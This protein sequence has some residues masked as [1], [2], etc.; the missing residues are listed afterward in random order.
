MPALD[1]LRATAIL[2]VMLSHAGLGKMIPGGFGV[3]IFFF[4]SGYLIT[5][6]LRIE[7]IK[8][9]RVSLKAFYYKRTLR[10]M[11]PMFLTIAFVAMLSLYGF[12][13]RAVT[14]AGVASD[15]AFLTNYAP[16]LGLHGGVGIPL[17]SLDV[18]EHYYILFSTLFAVA[19]ARMDGNRAAV[20]CLA[21]TAVPLLFRIGMALSGDDLSNVFYWTHTRLDSILWGSVLAFWQNPAIDRDAW[22]PK[23]WHFAAALFALAVC[24]VIR[25]EVFRETIRYTIQGAALLVIFSFLLQDRSIMARVLGSSPLRWI[26]LISYTLYLAHMPALAIAEHLGWPAPVITGFLVAFL[27]AIVMRIIV[28]RPLQALRHSHL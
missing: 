23:L 22:K 15:F 9:G 11:P 27:Y 24:L 10:I 25:S 8:T 3:T 19:F 17:W 4:L 5:T 2:I 18:E 13:G 16:Q 14:T 1:G 28:E 12:T 20:V 21:L 26:A 6:L 7:A